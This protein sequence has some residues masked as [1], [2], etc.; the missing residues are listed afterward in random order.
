M[1]RKLTSI[2]AGAALFFAAAS[3][4]FA[5]GESGGA[6]TSGGATSGGA[7]SGGA[8]EAAPAPAPEEAPAPIP[9]GPPA[10]VATAPVLSDTALIGIGAAALIAGIL[11]AVTSHSS[12]STATGTR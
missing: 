9:P 1:Q 6:G 11:V 4:A 10:P 2:L 5:Q 7:T 8:P 12:S 3:S